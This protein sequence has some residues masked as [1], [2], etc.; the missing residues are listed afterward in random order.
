MNIFEKIISQNRE[1]RKMITQQIDELT[2]E[3]TEIVTKLTKLHQLQRNKEETLREQIHFPETKTNKSQEQKKE[4]I[5]SS[6]LKTQLA[7]L[8]DKI[9]MLEETLA[10]NRQTITELKNQI[11]QLPPTKYSPISNLGFGLNRRKSKRKYNKSKRNHNK[12]NRK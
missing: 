8:N 4:E 9:A 10:R 2:L 3:N 7:T 1:N 11:S 12:T 6:P 5:R